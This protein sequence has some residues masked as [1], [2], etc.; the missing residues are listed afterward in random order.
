MVCKFLNDNFRVKGNEGV[1][2]GSLPGERNSDGSFIAKMRP[3]KSVSIPYIGQ[4]ATKKKQASECFLVMTLAVTWSCGRLSFCSTQPFAK[5]WILGGDC[6]SSGF[7]CIQTHQLTFPSSFLPQ[8]SLENEAFA[9]LSN[10]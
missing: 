3:N 8:L 2:S 10:A 7:R 1:S 4:Q 9:H 6:S 5:N